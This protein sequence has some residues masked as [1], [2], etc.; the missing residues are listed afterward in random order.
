MNALEKRIKS[1]K[2]ETIKDSL[3]LID[4]Q[5]EIDRLA[6]RAAEAEGIKFDYTNLQILNKV[7]YT[8]VT[9]LEVR[10]PEFMR[11]YLDERY[12]GLEE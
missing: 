7:R 12:A 8:L 2:T 6:S 5:I 3:K 9:A 10:D 4:L 11:T 1:E